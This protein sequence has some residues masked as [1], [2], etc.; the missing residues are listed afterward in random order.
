MFFFHV[1][2]RKKMKKCASSWQNLQ[3]AAAAA[4]KATATGLAAMEVTALLTSPAAAAVPT[5][6]TGSEMARC[7]AC[8]TGEC[9]SMATTGT[10]TAAPPAPA[11]SANTQRFTACVCFTLLICC[12]VGAGLLSCLAFW[13]VDPNGFQYMKEQPEQEQVDGVFSCQKNISRDM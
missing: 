10:S 7:G 4:A 2:S 13:Q 5:M 11:K 8:K 9:T 3:T 1:C 6:S 12:V